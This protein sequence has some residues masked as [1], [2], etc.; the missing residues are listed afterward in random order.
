MLPSEPQRIGRTFP[1]IGKVIWIECFAISGNADHFPHEHRVRAELDLLYQSA[2][3]GMG[4]LPHDRAHRP[5]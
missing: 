4:E 5:R 2:F 3:D 1:D